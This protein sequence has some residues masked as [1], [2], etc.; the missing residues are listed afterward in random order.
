MLGAD[1]LNSF[2]LFAIIML[3]KLEILEIYQK[4]QIIYFII[5]KKSNFKTKIRIRH[6][7]FDSNDM[8]S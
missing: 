5:E 2:Y 4:I 3:E 7:N 6:S 1:F 8:I